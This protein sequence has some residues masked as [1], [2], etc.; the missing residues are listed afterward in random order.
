M[1]D[2]LFGDVSPSGK[3]PVTFYES[4]EK[5]PDFT[6]YSMSGRTY[7]YTRDNVL[8]PFG[9]G[10]TYGN[11]TVT[12]LEYKDG[13]AIVTAHN[14]GEATD[15]VIQ[16]YIKAKCRYAAQNPVLC[17]FKRVHIGNGEDVTLEIAIADKAFTTVSDSGERGKFCEDFT[18][19]A[20]THQ[21]DELS[22][23]LSD[24][25][26][27]E[28]ISRRDIYTLQYIAFTRPTAALLRSVLLL[29]VKSC[30]IIKQR[31]EGDFVQLYKR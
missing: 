25:E 6:D 14:G 30:G 8:Y 21:P 15:D 2:I 22:C 18:L 7:R 23:K 29:I 28:L 26:C 10:L 1:A 16:L 19:Y 4:A 13:K 31:Y 3:L 27:I 12:G 11:V 9:Y 17:G 20:G 24:T 5:L